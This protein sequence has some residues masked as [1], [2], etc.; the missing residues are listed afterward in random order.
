[1]LLYT[2]A[3]NGNDSIILS[4]WGCGAYRCPP[5]AVASLFKIVIGEFAGVFK[6][7]PFAVLYDNFKPFAD[8]FNTT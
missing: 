5:K 6:E 3:K 8:E 7:T 1:M 4:A 2:A